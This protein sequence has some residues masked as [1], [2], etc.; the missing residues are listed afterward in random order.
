VSVRRVAAASIW[1]RLFGRR[2]YSCIAE[3]YGAPSEER[4]F[5]ATDRLRALAE[6]HGGMYDGW[7][8][9]VER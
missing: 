6:R 3:E 7:E 5:A 4:V 2:E 1:R 9:S 8:A